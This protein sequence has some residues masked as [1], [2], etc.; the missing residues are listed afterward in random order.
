[1]EILLAIWEFFQNN[2]LT[3][4]QFFIGF[5]VFAGYMLLRKPVYE[6][7]AGFIKAVVG[8]MI[9]NVASGGLVS[10]FRPV[11]AGL[12]TEY[13]D[14][15]NILTSQGSADLASL[16]SDTYFNYFF[17]LRYSGLNRLYYPTRGMDFSAGYTLYTD[18]FLHNAG[19]SPVSAL[20]ASWCSAIS[21]GSRST[22]LPSVSARMLFGENIPFIYSNVL[23]GNFAGKF[24]PQQLPFVGMTS[25]ERAEKSLLLGGLTWQQCL[26]GEHYLSLIGNVAVTHG[27]LHRLNDGKSVYGVGLQY[28]YNSKLGPLEAVVSYGNNNKKVVCFINLG[29]YF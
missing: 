11:L 15:G 13:Y 22:L 16:R 3:K 9:L 10:N 29:F 2:I 19:E 4:P 7:L 17:R 8:Y 14:Y 12:Q 1:M 23:G 20:C 18:D 27:E 24:M 21:L 6:C 5:I 26:G 28:G 25:T